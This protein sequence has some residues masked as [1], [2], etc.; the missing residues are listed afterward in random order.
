[1]AKGPSKYKH[2]PMSSRGRALEALSGHGGNAAGD[3]YETYQMTGF[4]DVPAMYDSMAGVPKALT[5]GDSKPD[6][7]PSPFR[8]QAAPSTGITSPIPYISGKE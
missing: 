3:A 1:M 5:R 4:E 7:N 6:L 2:P 8:E